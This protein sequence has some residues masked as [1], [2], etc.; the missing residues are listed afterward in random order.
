MSQYSIGIVI[1]TYNES[2][3]ITL[4]LTQ[5]SFAVSKLGKKVKILVMDDNS[6]DG[7]SKIVENYITQ[8]DNT[9]LEITIQVR[10]KK[11]GLASAYKQGFAVL[12]QDCDYLMSM[13]ADLSHKPEYLADF[14]QKATEG[15]D[16]IIGS[17]NI[18]GGSVEDWAFHRKM[19]SKLASVYC[20]IILWTNIHDFTGGYNMYK[21]SIFDKLNFEDIQAEGYLFQIEMKYRISRF[22]FS[23]CEI[24]I[25]FPDRIHGKSK[26]SKQIIFE[27]FIGV[28]KL[29]F[30]LIKH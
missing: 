9:L 12:K 19:I 3:S 6:P 22:G 27:A 18:R 26:F 8:N 16:M 14:W 4:L 13:D 23:F 10:E 25:V 5:V 24:P 20:R 7:T 11:M 30:G 2:E 1:P 28:W 17:R 29:K 21:S 15:K